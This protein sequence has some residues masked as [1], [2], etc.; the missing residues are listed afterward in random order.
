MSKE[1]FFIPFEEVQK[2]NR[3][4]AELA[5]KFKQEDQEYNRR[6]H[7]EQQQQTSTS[8]TVENTLKK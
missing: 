6:Y 2:R 5:K 8:V 7:P 4:F 3:E 1:K